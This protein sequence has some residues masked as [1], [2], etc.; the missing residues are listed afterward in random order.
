MYIAINK[1]NPNERHSFTWTADDKLII[2]GHEV[3]PNDWDIV[4]TTITADEE[5]AVAFNE[6]KVAS[7]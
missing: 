7:R 3:S 6:Q 2:N 5:H 1:S 4:E